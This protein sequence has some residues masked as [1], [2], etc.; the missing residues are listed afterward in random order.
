MNS[1][2]LAERRVSPVI[3]FGAL[4]CIVARPVTSTASFHAGIVLALIYLL[5][6]WRPG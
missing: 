6:V 2:H 5:I 4:F 1:R 3:R